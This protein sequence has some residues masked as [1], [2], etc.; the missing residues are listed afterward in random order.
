[1]LYSPF[2]PRGAIR[3]LL[4]SFPAPKIPAKPK[5]I[6]EFVRQGVHLEQLSIMS[7]VLFLN[8]DKKINQENPKQLQSNREYEEVRCQCGQLL[9]KRIKGGIEVKCRRCKQ[10]R[11]IP[12]HSLNEPNR[13]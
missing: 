9:V 11:V 5:R 10:V 2:F 13:Q 8:K 1:M 6:V 4:N 3:L 12:F 7:M